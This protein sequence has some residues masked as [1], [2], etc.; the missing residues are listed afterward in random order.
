MW[1][2]GNHPVS[3]HIALVPAGS[4]C[5]AVGA[6]TAMTMSI[7]SKVTASMGLTQQILNTVTTI[8]ATMRF[9]PFV[10]MNLTQDPTN[11]TG[12]PISQKQ[13]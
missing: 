13:G 9:S 10:D 11:T 12:E 2:E 7:S 3:G 6:T 8:M 5:P 4:N 1:V